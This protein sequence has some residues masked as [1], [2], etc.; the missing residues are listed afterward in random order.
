MNKRS[1]AKISINM[2]GNF[3]DL[4]PFVL[5]PNFLPNTALMAF[6]GSIRGNEKGLVLSI[7]TEG[8]TN[9]KWLEPPEGREVN[10]DFCRF[11]LRRKQKRYSFGS[12]PIGEEEMKELLDVIA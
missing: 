10:L 3:V 8:I 6:A 11:R 12:I 9:L 2:N 4:V 7:E 1:I 5:H